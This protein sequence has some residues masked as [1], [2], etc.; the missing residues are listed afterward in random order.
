MGQINIDVSDLRTKDL[1][2]LRNEI[3]RELYARKKAE[4]GYCDPKNPHRT[5][6]FYFKDL[7]TM[8]TFCDEYEDRGYEMSRYYDNSK[9]AICLKDNEDRFVYNAE[10]D[11]WFGRITISLDM[12]TFKEIKEKYKVTHFVKYEKRFNGTKVNIAPSDTYILEMEVPN[13]ET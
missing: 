13:A 11:E 4:E 6:I 5:R 10:P 7:T 1:I 12:K 8:C 9:V 2:S 3:N